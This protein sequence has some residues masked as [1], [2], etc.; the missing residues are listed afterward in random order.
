MLVDTKLVVITIILHAVTCPHVQLDY[1]NHRNPALVG[2]VATLS[3]PPGMVLTG[4]NATTCIEN[5]QWHPDPKIAMC[6]G[7]S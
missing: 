1:V 3:C 7:I 6:K 4:P 2:T 5:R